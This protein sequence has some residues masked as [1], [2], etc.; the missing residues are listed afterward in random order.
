VRYG[1]AEKHAVENLSDGDYESII[2]ELKSTPT[3]RNK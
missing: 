3:S 2:V 1:N